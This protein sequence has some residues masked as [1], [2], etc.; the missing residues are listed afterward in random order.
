MKLTGE[1]A[2]PATRQT[3]WEALNDPAVLQASIPGC[4]SLEATAEN[5]F[6]A[7]VVA[8][9][10]PVKAKFKGK[11]TLSD[12]TP[13]ESYRI[14]GEGQGGAAGFAKGGAL[15]TLTADGDNTVLS[16][17]VDA[18]VGGKLAQI[19]QR[20]IDAAAKKMADDF[21]TTFIVQILEPAGPAVS[22]PANDNAADPAPADPD[23]GARAGM[24]LLAA[25]FVLALY[26]QF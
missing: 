25:V 8:R 12:L 11:V 5:E 21:F 13:P 19:G 3:V 1:Y 23:R 2:I 14:T 10:G 15:V 24:I 22:T 9:V 6:T 4:N 18:T 26:S 17:E 7:Q 20:L 16:Y